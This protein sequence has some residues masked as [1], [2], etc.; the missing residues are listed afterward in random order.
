M[1]AM[2]EENEI[3][4][5]FYL[6]AYTHPMTLEIIRTNDNIRAKQ[7][8]A[9]YTANWTEEQ[10]TEAETLI[11]GI[12]YATLMNTPSSAP[13]HIRVAGALETILSIYQVPPEIRRLK[14]EKILA[15]DYRTIGRRILKEFMEYIEIVNEDALKSGGFN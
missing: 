14:M 5:D 11:S 4:R 7:V 13:L 3:A 2:C 10:F 1:A 8:Y 6:S 9:P 12:E 15:M